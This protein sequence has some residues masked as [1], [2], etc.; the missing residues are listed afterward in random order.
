M[1][2]YFLLLFSGFITGS[3][4]QLQVYDGKAIWLPVAGATEKF[5]YA[6]NDTTLTPSV[7]YVWQLNI[8][9]KETGWFEL[10]H[11]KVNFRNRVPDGDFEMLHY[12]LHLDVGAFDLSGVK[13]TIKGNKTLVKGKYTRGIISSNWSFAYGAYNDRD[14]SLQTLVYSPT[15]NTWTFQADSVSFTGKVNPSGYFDGL[16]RFQFSQHQKQEHLYQNGILTQ[17][18]VDGRIPF[19]NYWTTVA[20]HLTH[21]DSILP[22]QGSEPFFWSAGFRERDSLYLIQAKPVTAIRKALHPYQIAAK[23]LSAHP[24]LDLPY[25]KGTSRLYFKLSETE[26]SSLNNSRQKLLHYDSTLRAKL[27]LPV[28]QLRR[29]GYAPLDSL[30]NATETLIADITRQNSRIQNFLLETAR[31]IAPEHL[32]AERNMV[33]ISHHDYAHYLNKTV[34]LLTLQLEKNQVALMEA[35]EDLRVREAAEELEEEWVYLR[36]AIDTLVSDSNPNAFDNIIYNRFIV[37]DFDERKTTFSQLDSYDARRHYLQ[38]TVDYYTYFWNF[39]K[40]NTYLQLTDVEAEFMQQYTKYL[41]NPYMGVNN[42]EV[43]VRKKF[44]NRTLTQFWPYLIT[45]L[46]QAEDGEQFQ[47]HFA[48][49]L[50]YKAALLHLADDNQHDANRLERRGRKTENMQVFEEFVAD[51][52]AHLEK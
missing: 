41:Y 9:N 33:F 25:I 52:A 27:Q 19:K 23:L 39:F 12:T 28:I 15:Q 36:T 2:I 5:R 49:A 13:T 1:R 46:Q 17:L 48:R 3:Y 29:S 11:I 31:V 35:I 7:E 38:E 26:R 8:E 34:D 40:S 10:A 47:K 42:V 24:L 20:Q 6:S 32:L 4:A 51:Y 16:W 22:A 50:E 30:L 21:A 44:L 45:K 18:Q 14:A 43:V 37:Q